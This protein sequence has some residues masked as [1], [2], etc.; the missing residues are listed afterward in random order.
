MLPGVSSV[1]L[2]VLLVF[3][4]LQDEVRPCVAARQ[5]CFDEVRPWVA[6]YQLHV[7]SAM[8]VCLFFRRQTSPRQQQAV[9]ESPGA[10]VCVCVC[11]RERPSVGV[12][13]A[14]VMKV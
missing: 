6:E 7:R 10:R 5:L 1:S 9:S 14:G 12:L 8:V 11:V 13:V 3:L 2:C 4:R